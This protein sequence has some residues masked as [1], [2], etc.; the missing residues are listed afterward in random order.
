M[1]V[2]FIIIMMVL[3]GALIGG[4]TNYLAIKMLFRPYEPVYIGKWRLPFTPGL[5]PK[6]REELAAQLG[7]VVTDYLVTSDSLERKVVD[8]QFQQQMVSMINRQ[9]DD[10]VD[11]KLTTIELLQKINPNF[12][13]NQV[14]QEV[15]QFISKKLHQLYEQYKNQSLED[16]LPHDVAQNIER[17]LPELSDYVLTQIE[18][19]LLSEEGKQKISDSASKFLQTQGFLGNMVSSYLGEDG[20]AEKITPAITM[21]LNSDETKHSVENLIRKEWEKLKGQNLDEIRMNLG[22]P[23]IEDQVSD[24]LLNELDITSVANNPIGELMSDY[25]SNI[26]RT[27]VPNLVKQLL[28]QLSKQMPVLLK[29]LDLYDLVKKEVESF[30]VSR[31]E[32]LVLEITKR[33]MNM[34]TYLGAFLGGMIGL[35][36]GVIVILI[37]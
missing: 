9:I 16:I 17:N 12:E 8:P 32:R 20:L 31:I 33:E 21:F 10:V 6:R 26:K 7:K 3:I 22:N 14:E 18:G 19:F 27:W 29:Q 28:L 25:I 23:A 11:R 30:D 15:D 34:I 24:I 35:I 1:N 5:I 36:Q 13:L 2:A 37:A 4:M